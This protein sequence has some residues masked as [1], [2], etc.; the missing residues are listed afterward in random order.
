MPQVRVQ[1]HRALGLLFIGMAFVALLGL[2]WLHPD[3]LS[4]AVIGFLLRVRTHYASDYS[5]I[6]FSRIRE[7]MTTAQVERFLGPPLHAWEYPQ[8][9]RTSWRYTDNAFGED[10]RVRAVTFSNGVVSGAESY[11]HID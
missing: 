6:N 2:H 4:G 11:L 8:F 10:Y 7:G 9:H 5:Y 1:K 3:R